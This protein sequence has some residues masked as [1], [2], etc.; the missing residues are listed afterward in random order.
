[1]AN[2]GVI[3][4]VNA[5]EDCISPTGSVAGTAQYTISGGTGSF[6]DATGRGNVTVAAQITSIGAGGIDGTFQQLTFDGTLAIGH[7]D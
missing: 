2:Q 3:H 6:E 1:M 7:E 5:G 4:F